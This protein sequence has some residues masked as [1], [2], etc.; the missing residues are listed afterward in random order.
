METHNHINK[1]KQY[2]QPNDEKKH[3]SS[4]QQ[5]NEEMERFNAVM[6]ATE[7]GIWDWN[8]I[9]GHVYYSPAWQTM[10]GYEVGEIQQNVEAWSKI[11]HPDDLEASFAHALRFINNESN[12]YRMEFRMLCKDGSYK[13]VL[14]R[15]KDAKRDENGNVTR[16]IGTHVD[17]QERKMYEKE[18]EL[19]KEKTDK[20]MERFNEAMLATEDGIWDWNIVTGEVYFSPAWQTMLGYN[21]GEI[22]QDVEAWTT[23]LHPDDLEPTINHAQKFIKNESNEYRMEFRMLCKDGSYKWVLARAKDAERDSSGNVTRIIGTHVDI[24][25]KKNLELELIK[26][27]EEA[28]AA[29]L[30]KSEFISNMSHEIRTPMNAIIGFA[31]ILSKASLPTK[32]KRQVQ[33]IQKSGESLIAI[34]NDIL[35]LSKIEAGKMELQPITFNLFSTIEDIRMIF[36]ENIS[37]K[38]LKFLSNI[39]TNLPNTIVL[40]EIRLRQVLFNLISNAIKFTHKGSISIDI[41]QEFSDINESYIDLKISISDTGIGISEENRLN[42]FKAFEQQK[43]QSVKKYGGTG[44]GLSISKQLIELM[45]GTIELESQLNKGSTFHIKINKIPIGNSI[46]HEEYDQTKEVFKFDKAKVLIVDDVDTNLM[47]IRDYFDNSNLEII[48]ATN[49]K[50]AIQ[51]VELHNPDVILMDLQ[52]PIM[53]GKESA[54]ILKKDPKSSHIPIIILSATVIKDEDRKENDLVIFDTSL[55]KPI[56]FYTLDRTLGQFLSHSIDKVNSTLSNSTNNSNK[57]FLPNEEFLKTHLD[58]LLPLIQKSIN[59]G[60]LKDTYKLIEAMKKT[61]EIE[62]QT[63]E[64]I[65]DLEENVNNLELLRIEKILQLLYDKTISLLEER[66]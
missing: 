40:D 19:A 2:S 10:L 29:S 42:I 31:E 6:L 27:K 7:D 22:K 37:E 5:T 28:E 14:A 47:V 1:P 18:L 55:Q 56:S 66:R 52:M 49:G 43:G 45:G 48:E 3:C 13:W 21:V 30:A 26:A 59:S 9:T 12:E 62:K 61:D 46:S 57:D 60:N 51:M 35:D 50:E 20:A 11:V 34:I 4:K 44:L 16:I 38:G 54:R 15:A 41:K 23:I 25:E 58:L 24:Q 64:F 33:T 63:L 32:E 39:D 8:I 65:Q 17:I 53:D 36:A